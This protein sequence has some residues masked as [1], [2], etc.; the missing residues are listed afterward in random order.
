M[1]FRSLLAVCAF[2]LAA[3]AAVYGCSGEATPEDLCAWLQNP[4]E[5]TSNC[6]SQFHEDIKDRCG[7]LDPATVTGIFSTRAALDTCV[8]TTKGGAVVFD[9]PIDLAQFPPIV[10]TTMKIS[11]TDGTSCGEITY[12][13]KFSWSLKIDAP[14]D[15]NGAAGGSTGSTSST[16]GSASYTQGTIAVSSTGGQ[17]IQITCPAPNVVPTGTVATAETHTFNLNQVL[18]ATEK[19]GCPQYSEIIPQAILELNPGGVDRVGSLLLWIQ[20]PREATKMMTTSSAGGG[21]TATIAPEVVYYFDCAIP[22]APRLCADGMKNASEADID[23]GGPESMPACPPRC[24]VDQHCIVDCD[25]DAS[26]TCQIDTKDGG[27]KKCMAPSNG[28][29]PAPRTCT[30]LICSNKRPDGL[31][32]DVDCGGGTCPKCVAGQ[33]CKASS[34]CASGTCTT[35][36]CQ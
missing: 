8:L 6:V 32:S 36:T 22:A 20:L 27:I 17:T 2:P 11:N 16:G 35:M 7:A 34:D 12:L 30:G 1:R 5:G 14:S 24:T 23:C 29:P 33:K 26:T 3:T 25:C 19:N 10:P 31:E 4:I 21:S 15:T 13:S 28:I 18:A 9:P